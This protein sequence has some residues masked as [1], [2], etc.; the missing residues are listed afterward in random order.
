MII[1]KITAFS[2][3]SITGY[4]AGQML[5][6]LLKEALSPNNNIRAISKEWVIKNWGK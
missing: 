4:H 2:I 5:C 3:Y 1:D 6:V